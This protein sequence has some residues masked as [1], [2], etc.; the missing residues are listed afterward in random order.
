MS[1]ILSERKYNPHLDRLFK[2]GMSQ[3][4]DELNQYYFSKNYDVDVYERMQDALQVF[5]NI[6][7]E[8]IIKYKANNSFFPNIKNDLIKIDKQLKYVL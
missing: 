1:Y 7:K 3:Y 2:I 6:C 8:Y 4:A 5:D